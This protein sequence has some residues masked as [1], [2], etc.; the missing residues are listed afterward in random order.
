MT[1][2]WK[3]RVISSF[4]CTYSQVVRVKLFLYEL[5]RVTLFYNQAEGQGPLRKAILFDYST[6]SRAF[7]VVLVVMNPPANAGVIKEVA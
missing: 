2:L 5:N 3:Q 1:C 4:C 7:Q 6:K